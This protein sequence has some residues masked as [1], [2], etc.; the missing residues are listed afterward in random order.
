ML[1]MNGAEN[2]PAHS[3]G[4]DV[5]NM[6]I[7]HSN[8]PF[9]AG[10]SYIQLDGGSNVPLSADL[11]VDL[12]LDQWVMGL[13]YTED[14]FSVSFMYEQGALNQFGLISNSRIERVRIGG[15]DATNFYLTGSYTFGNNVIKAAYGQL[16]PGATDESKID[17]YVLGY[18]YS[19]SERTLNLGRVC[20]PQRR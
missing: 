20:G 13:G 19:L 1:V 10:A 2:S 11:S 9:F 15:D 8:G 3:E 14:A 6:A 16:D 18:Q 12:D 17:N 5:W 4:I 7:K